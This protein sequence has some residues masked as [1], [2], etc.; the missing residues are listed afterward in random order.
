MSGVQPTFGTNP[1]HGHNSNRGCMASI[2]GFILFVIVVIYGFCAK[3]YNTVDEKVTDVRMG[4]RDIEVVVVEG[5][6]ISGHKLVGA[7]QW[8]AT[9]EEKREW[10][11]TLVDV[12]DRSGQAYPT[13]RL[14]LG[15]KIAEDVD[16]ILYPVK[17]DMPSQ[18]PTPKYI[19]VELDE[20]PI[21][22]TNPRERKTIEYFT[23]MYDDSTW[24]PIYGVFPSQES[25][26]KW[27]EQNG[28]EETHFTYRAFYD[29]MGDHEHDRLR[30]IYLELLE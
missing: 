18:H 6:T 7:S 29:S 8:K 28:F 24:T 4:M 23:W 1:M 11:H 15:G 9:D 17:S 25:A 2:G 16:D 26:T 5:P 13:C 3:V 14:K 10:M 27:V 20:K 21:K 19:W 12:T 22:P 30:A